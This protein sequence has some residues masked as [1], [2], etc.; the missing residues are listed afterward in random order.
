MTTQCTPSQLKRHPLG[1][2]EVI[3]RQIH[4][5]LRPEGIGAILFDI[6]IGIAHWLQREADRARPH[7]FALGGAVVSNLCQASFSQRHSYSGTVLL[8]S[9][10]PPFSGHCGAYSS[11]L[12]RGR[13]RAK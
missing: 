2:R 4:E 5:S 7:G 10:L 6:G 1:R 12:G 8:P 3:W 9:R 13:W 11:K